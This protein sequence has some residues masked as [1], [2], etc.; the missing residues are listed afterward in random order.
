ML[1]KIR[2]ISVIGPLI[3]S[4]L[5][6]SASA[7]R[8]TPDFSLN[9]WSLDRPQGKLYPNE[10]S[11]HCGKIN[12]QMAF[13]DTVGWIKQCLEP[14]SLSE[15][16]TLNFDLQVA[17]PRIPPD[18]IPDTDTH[19]PDMSLKVIGNPKCCA[20]DKFYSEQA[21]LDGSVCADVIG[22]GTVHISQ[23][24]KGCAGFDCSELFFDKHPDL[25]GKVVVVHMLP[26]ALNFIQS[27]LVSESEIHSEKNLQ[28]VKIDDLDSQ[29]L[30]AWRDDWQSYLFIHQRDG[31]LTRSELLRDAADINQRHSKLFLSAK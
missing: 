31:D 10:H 6:L 15:D 30:T 7:S 27:R 25:K 23:N 2:R 19:P 26:V 5:I 24:E 1:Q 11:S 13:N 4:A 3:S 22:S 20:A 17:R 16:A 21:I 29:Q 8:T 12:N 9:D 18:R 28:A 14:R